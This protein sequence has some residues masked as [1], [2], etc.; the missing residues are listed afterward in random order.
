MRS[1]EACTILV[2]CAIKKLRYF[3]A[4]VLGW[5]GFSLKMVVLVVI[6]IKPRLGVA[7]RAN[8][9]TSLYFWTV[10]QALGPALGIAILL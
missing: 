4:M 2:D 1:T 10:L 6:W 8:K 9:K 7:H 5:G 3:M